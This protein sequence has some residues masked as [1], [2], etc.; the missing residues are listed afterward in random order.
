MDKKPTDEMRRLINLIE[1]INTPASTDVASN[2]FKRLGVGANKTPNI[3][4]DSDKGNSEPATAMVQLMVGEVFHERSPGL[5]YFILMFPLVKGSVQL[6]KTKKTSG[7]IYLN[8]AW[9]PGKGEYWHPNG[10][11][12]KVQTTIYTKSDG[13]HW[14][15]ESAIPSSAK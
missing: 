15:M 14:A 1:F 11:S 4:D 8:V 2:L 3:D 9:V 6:S 5:E 10:C 12:G 7:Q 13:T